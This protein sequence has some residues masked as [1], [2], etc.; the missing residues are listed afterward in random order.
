MYGSGA[1][2]S[3]NINC[4][5]INCNPFYPV[6]DSSTVADEY[7]LTIITGTLNIATA[8]TYYFGV[9]GDDAVEVM[10]DGTVVAGWYNGHGKETKTVP[11][12]QGSIYLDAG[13]HVVE[14][15]HE[16]GSGS[17]SYYLWWKPP[18]ASAWEITPASYFS[19][20]TLAT[21][22]FT[23]SASTITDY[24]VRVQVGRSDLPDS[25]AVEYPSGVYKP[26]GLLQKFGDGDRMKFGLLTGSYRNNTTGGVLRKNIGTI[27]DEIVTTTGQ[28]NSSV[29]GIIQT[30]D[31]FKIKGFSNESGYSYSDNC[32][33]I[34]TRPIN[35][36]ECRM[37]GNPIAEMMYE[38][39]R[40][41]AG[42][43]APTAAFVSNITNGGDD[44]LALPLAAWTDPFT[45][46]SSCAKP[47]MLVISDI[48]P[49]YDSDEIPG[50][51][52]NTYSGSLGTMNVKTLADT[53]S[54][55]EGVGASADTD[56]YIGQSL[57]ASDTA[58]T[59]KTVSSLGSVRGLCPEEPTKRGSYYSASV[60]YY[61]HVNDIND[62]DDSQT[63]RTYTVGLASPLPKIEIPVNG[64][65]MTLV[66]FGKSVG[67]YSIVATEGSF[68]PT[69]TIVDFY[70]QELTPTYGKF[71]INFEDVEQ[72]A[73]H[74]MDAIIIYEYT[75]NAD[76][77]VT[78]TLT[79]EYAAGSIM[80][81]IGYIISGTTNDGIFLEV[82][83]Q[84][85]SESSDP[86]YFLD[87]PPDRSAPRR[88][89]STTKLPLVHTR[90]FYPGSN[91][92]A[93]L[94]ENPLMYAAKWGAFKD[95]NNNNVPDLAVE[96]DED[97]DGAPDT[98][99][100]VNNP[101]YLE[102]KL[103]EA[104]VDILRK[105]SSGTAV[106]VLATSSEG[107]GTLVQAYFKAKE[108][109]G[110]EDVSWVGYLH[111]LWVDSLGRIR[112]DSDRSGTKP[113]LVVARD[114][115]VEFFFDSASGEAK[116]YRYELDSRGEPKYTITDDDGDGVLEDGETIV[117]ER[118]IH[119]ID[120][121]EPIWEA[122]DLLNTKEASSRRIKTFVDLNHD[123]VVNSSEYID[124]SL[125]NI[126]SLTPFL[127]VGVDT[128][129]DYLGTTKAARAS[130]AIKFIRGDDSSY[131][132]TTD[133]RYRKINGAPWKLGDIVHS[134][135]VTLGRPMDNY[136]L[137]Y[138]DQ[139]YA[140]YYK[141]YQGREQVVFVG[142]ND[143]LLHAFYLGK[144]VS[145]NDTSTS[146]A[147][148]EIY[149][150]KAGGVTVDH[151][152]ELWGFIPQALLPH[153]KWLADPDY[154]HVYY[155]DLKP[156]LVDARVFTDDDV[157]PNGWGTILLGGLNLGGGN[158]TVTDTFSVDP[159]RDFRPSF[160][161][162]DVTD[163][164]NPTLMWEKSYDGLGKTTAVPTVAKIE[165][166]WFCLLSSGPTSYSGTS[167]QPAQV[168]VVNLVDGYLRRRLEAS[169][170]QAFM[171]GAVAVDVGLNYNVDTG[172]VGE[173]Y[174]D[175]ENST[176]KGMVYRF[177]S[178]DADG[179]YLTNPAEWTFTPLITTDGPVT[180]SPAVS[181]DAKSNL[182]VYYGTGRFYSPADKADT[183]T[184]YFYGVK[185]PYY[186]TGSSGLYDEEGED[187]KPIPSEVT[188]DSLTLFNSTGVNVYTDR[189]VDGAGDGIDTWSKLLQAMNGYDGW[190]YTLGYESA[191][192]GERVL[193]KPTVLGGVVFDTTFVPNDDPCAFDGNSNLLGLY[194][195]TGTAYVDE[196]FTGGGGSS[197]V[198]VEGQEKTKVSGK[199]SVG[200][201]RGSGVSI[202]VGSQEGATGYVQQ[203]TGIVEQI[204]LQPAFKVRSGFVTWRER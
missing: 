75:L 17:D 14:F 129:Y 199:I 20:L 185:D 97:E 143:G 93:T 50:S 19:D 132:G 168:L 95:I 27:T 104:F 134:T 73:D 131:T 165:D 107:E 39:M 140:D 92:P 188:P 167:A 34:A 173:A 196:V 128:V 23:V 160:F 72:G 89:S 12:Y 202:H 120:D 82:R 52:F 53:I 90:T 81:H 41:F 56:H 182:W 9:N 174:W 11:T 44:G 43:S 40:Y 101:L 62:A 10:I 121:L 65:T 148:E 163:P 21:Y 155:V 42:E 91:P 85:T 171:T 161:A 119:T 105:S 200:V 110:T 136:G 183:T 3:G 138:G 15:H 204:E 162:I 193:N 69:N 198:E 126:D 197:T 201:G 61:G 88:G 115:I 25:N 36:G 13:E 176:W 80:Q 70:V 102:Q 2:T 55:W 127:G 164:H 190:R 172:Y 29:N 147:T 57:A 109:S 98:Y 106:S 130:N 67:G 84:D 1:P 159:T 45:T 122:G 28:F 145:G 117:Y 71:R 154:T 6:P 30:I 156:K 152:E 60:A 8:G 203:S 100:Y 191:N 149:F 141:Y 179:T 178:V 86:L 5:T 87:T 103:T 78:I 96:W 151:G 64:Q 114:K 157:H 180:A 186:N 32:G 158:I 79:S 139:T 116:F 7:Y 192:I 169:E 99:F 170:S 77:S 22:N 26:T 76:N 83:D 194:Y 195:E 35:T 111:T 150:D 51:Y 137:I 142:A 31:K 48:N 125:E 189:T 123:E 144:Y 112:E 58:C 33:W 133:I 16:E 38:G 108:N 184:Q 124:F 113:G 46:N 175:D 37:W 153:L 166:E 68:Q 4:G 47:F 118:T 63:V 24:N 54:S 66:P 74:D 94:L 146:D 59:A 18:S 135:P 181:F 187:D 49:S 177:R